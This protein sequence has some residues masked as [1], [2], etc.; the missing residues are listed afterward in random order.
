MAKA[1][2]RNKPLNPSITSTLQPA[3]MLLHFLKEAKGESFFTG[4]QDK[5]PA[6]NGSCG[7]KI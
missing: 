5:H 2:N 1:I 6:R 4:L 3:P 7:S